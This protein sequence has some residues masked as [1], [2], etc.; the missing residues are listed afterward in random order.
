MNWLDFC[1]Y[2]PGWN[3]ENTWHWRMQH[4]YSLQRWSRKDVW[5][6]RGKLYD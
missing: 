3:C 5:C 4:L 6:R 2:I 1:L